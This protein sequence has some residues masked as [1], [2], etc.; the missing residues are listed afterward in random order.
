MH[1]YAS[2]SAQV[3]KNLLDLVTAP[4]AK[5]LL[6]LGLF[7]LKLI[8]SHQPTFETVVALSS[9]LLAREHMIFQIHS[10]GL[11]APVSSICA[12]LALCPRF[13]GALSAIELTGEMPLAHCSCLTSA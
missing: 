7:M 9:V 12:E 11:S 2:A 10:F 5:T 1:S 6:T 13:L 3:S 4:A 8:T